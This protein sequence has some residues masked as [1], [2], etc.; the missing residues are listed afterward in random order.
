MSL[1]RYL[2][3]WLASIRYSITRQLMFRVDFLVWLVTDLVWMVVNLLLIEVVFGHVE[4]LAGWTKH[5][6]LLLMGVSLMQMRLFTG[7][8]LTNLYEFGR[9][10]RTGNFDFQLAQP[11][12]VLFMVSTRKLELDGTLNFILATGITVWAAGKVG[13]TPS[14][15]DL[16]CFAVGFAAAM[17][18]HYSVLVILASSVFWIVKSEGVENG[19][20]TLMEFSRLPASAYRGLANTVFVWALP[21]VVVTYVPVETLRSGADVTLLLWLVGAAAAWFSLAVW[22]FERGLR[23]YA[24]AS[25]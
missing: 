17:A 23:R 4:E 14:A 3:I 1:Q 13:L 19:Y 6:M 12:R 16:A 21:V 22:T 10:V 15:L 8:F 2:R 24:S 11:G 20:F 25:S 9:N 18:I 5:E 7:L